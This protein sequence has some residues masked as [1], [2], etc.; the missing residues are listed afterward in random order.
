MSSES[1]A[2]D[3]KAQLADVQAALFSL[4][5][6]LMNLKLS[7]LELACMTDQDAQQ[8]AQLESERLMARLRG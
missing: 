8:Q 4:R 2:D 1:G 5:D 7:L 6:G 3:N